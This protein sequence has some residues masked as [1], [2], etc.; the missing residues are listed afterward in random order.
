MEGEAA[1][2]RAELD[3]F[4]LK[5]E[6]LKA[7]KGSVAL[8]QSDVKEK[9]AE[10]ERLREQVSKERAT[11]RANLQ[12]VMSVNAQKKALEDLLAQAQAQAAP[13]VDPSVLHG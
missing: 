8:L 6:A 7:Q 10:V 11:S 9:A 4:R 12:K 2:L 1:R 13:A 5:Y 3:E